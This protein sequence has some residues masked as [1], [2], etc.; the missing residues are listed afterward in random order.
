[1]I[2]WHI[3]IK[4]LDP[5]NH[6]NKSCKA[7]ENLFEILKSNFKLL[8]HFGGVLRGGWGQDMPPRPPLPRPTKYMKKYEPL[9]SLG[10]TQTLV[11]RPLKKTLF[12][13]A[14]SITQIK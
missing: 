3:I 9:W 13:W 7:L 11:V 4:Q 8:L 6:K 12:L 1:M 14:S 5:R 2:F 10:G